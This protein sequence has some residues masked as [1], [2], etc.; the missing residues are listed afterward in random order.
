MDLDPC[1]SAAGTAS[2]TSPDPRFPLGARLT[3]RP[4]FSAASKPEAEVHGC[5]DVVASFTFCVIYSSPDIG[6][7]DSALQVCV[8]VCVT[9]CVC[10]CVFVRVCIYGRF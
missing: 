4:E 3:L 9:V 2:G 8:T 5:L 1:A 10:V 6:K 7:R